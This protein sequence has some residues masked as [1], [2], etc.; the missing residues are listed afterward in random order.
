M[1]FIA[2]AFLSLPIQNDIHHTGVAGNNPLGLQPA[3]I[4][5][6]SI[7]NQYALGIY[8]IFTN[9]YGEPETKT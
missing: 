9:L 5:S 1:I 4:S 7:K 6:L 8:S 3:G 2:V